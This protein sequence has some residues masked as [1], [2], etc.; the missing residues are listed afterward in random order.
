MI[1]A[2]LTARETILV[3]ILAGLFASSRSR[4]RAFL[5]RYGLLDQTRYWVVPGLLAVPMTFIIATGGIDLS[6]GAIMALSGIVLG[7]LHV[8]Y[9]NGPIWLAAGAGLCRALRGRASMAAS[10]ATC[11]SPRSS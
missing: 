3:A 7:M 5:D 6:V 4:P 2:V 8:E 10:A 9:G 11:G 1:K